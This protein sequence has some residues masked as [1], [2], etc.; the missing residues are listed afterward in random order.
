ML[1]Q[2]LKKYFHLIL[3]PNLVTF[4]LDYKTYL[5]E[6]FWSNCFFL[7]RIKESKSF[8][9]TL[10]ILNSDLSVKTGPLAPCPCSCAPG[11]DTV[12][13]NLASGGTT[14]VAGVL[15]T[16]VYRHFLLFVFGI[17]IS[18]IDYLDQ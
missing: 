13:D 10:H 4:L 9:E 2:N 15:V 3:L 12:V 14:A 5:P 8:P 18:E 6:F 1:S 11:L 7:I 17:H 16:P